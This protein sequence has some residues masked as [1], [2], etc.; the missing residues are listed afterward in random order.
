VTTA[1]VLL[2]AALVSSGGVYLY[3]TRPAFK[4]F[5]A[6]VRIALAGGPYPPEA[7]EAPVYE[8]ASLRDDIGPCVF[9]GSD[10]DRA[11]Q[12]I[13]WVNMRLAEMVAADEE[14]TGLSDLDL[15]A[16]YVLPEASPEVQR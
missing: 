11:K 3:L 14:L 4:V 12:P 15:S 5:C 16:Y 10:L 8:R 7:A 13:G 6:Q 9:A 1:C 2:V